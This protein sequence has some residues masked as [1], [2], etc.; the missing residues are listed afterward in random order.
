MVAHLCLWDFL[1]GGESF[2]Q[3][4]VWARGQR[5]HESLRLIRPAKMQANWPGGQS[6]GLQ[7]VRCAHGGSVCTLPRPPSQSLRC[8][9]GGEAEHHHHLPNATAP[10]GVSSWRDL[11]PCAYLSATFLPCGT[12]T[13]PMAKALYLTTSASGCR[14]SQLSLAVP[15][16]GDQRGD[17]RSLLKINI[18]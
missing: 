16:K 8:T 6:V 10:P 14:C 5:V 18:D 4:V 11:N 17:Q 15:T 12:V 7:R 1:E 13:L 3:F 2:Q 9:N